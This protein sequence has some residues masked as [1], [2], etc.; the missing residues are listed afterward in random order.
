MTR[1]PTKSG[2]AAPFHCAICDQ[3]V[4]GR[5]ESWIGGRW[6]PTCFLTHTIEALTADADAREETA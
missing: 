5:S 1:R 2:A 4:T 6:Q 3:P